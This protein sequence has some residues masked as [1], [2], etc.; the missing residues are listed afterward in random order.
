MLR[1]LKGNRR[2]LGAT[3][4]IAALLLAACSSSVDE[5]SSS[6]AAVTAAAEETA[7]AG[8]VRVLDG[9]RGGAE[10]PDEASALGGGGTSAVTVLPAQ[11]SLRIIRDGRVDL[12]IDPGSFGQVAAQLRTIAEDLGGYVAGGETHLEEIDDV[13]YT[14]GWFT[15]R[16]PE[17]RFEEALAKVDGMGERLNLQVSSQDVTEEYVDLEGRLR[18]WRNQEAFYERLMDEATTIQDLVSLQ[19]EMQEVLLNIEQIEGRLRYLESRTDFS[20]LT[21]GLTEVPGAAPIAD[22]V[23]DD[24][25]ML[26]EALEQ[27]GT[28]LLGT[29]GFLIVAAAF[30]LP[31][32]IVA[33]IAYAVYRGVAG[34]RGRD[35]PGAESV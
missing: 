12:R 33:L 18:Y 16:V 24:P 30:L 27:A 21:V 11:Y 19:N 2:R 25:G 31:V 23:S 8:E 20:T 10:A 35:E 15:L 1:A 3:A 22:P 14:V 5:G 26:E 7:S 9:E 4:L 13:S 34:G 29:V 17:D 6:D 32:G 28:V